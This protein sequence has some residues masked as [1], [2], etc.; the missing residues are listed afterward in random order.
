MST[1]HED[2][3]LIQRAQDNPEEFAAL[4]NKYVD[5][6][7]QYVFYKTGQHRDTAEDLTAEVFLR[8]MR[9]LEKFKWQGHPYSSYLYQVARSVC[10]EQYARLEKATVD[11]EN[12]VIQDESPGGGNTG[13]LNAEL[14]ML[15]D[16]INA[17]DPPL[18]E[19]F[20]LRY[21]EDLP[22][23]EIAVIVGK[24]PGA[25]RTALSRAT[26]KLQAAYT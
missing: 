23:D 5:R 7:F 4:Y 14:R 3:Q 1:V 18:P 12:I 2:K 9:N 17:L 20:Q 13:E 22:F 21:I 15:W 6:I 19:M 25:V 10:Q 11:I 8:A 16:F 26:K 24:K